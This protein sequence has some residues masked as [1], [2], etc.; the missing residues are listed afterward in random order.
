MSTSSRCSSVRTAALVLALQH[1]RAEDAEPAEQGGALAEQAAS[2]GPRSSRPSPGPAST[3]QRVA[4]ACHPLADDPAPA[5]RAALRPARWCR[6]GVLE[7]QHRGRQLRGGD[8]HGR[9]PGGPVGWGLRVSPRDGLDDNPLAPTNP[10]S[11][12]IKPCRRPRP[13]V[14]VP[15]IPTTASPPSSGSA[16]SVGCWSAW[17]S[18]CSPGRS[19]SRSWTW[20]IGALLLVAAIGVALACLVGWLLTRRRDVV[21]LGAD[22]LPGPAGARRRGGGGAAGS[23]V[24]RGGHDHRRRRLRCVR[25]AAHR[26]TAPPPSR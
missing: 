1:Q 10:V 6:Q 11:C 24:E 17:R 2:R 26:R 21:R 7:A 16:W 23:E 13:S 5:A 4:Q 8:G 18:C 14:P 12:S 3:T 20:P 22:G 9:P 19:W 25:A 15:P